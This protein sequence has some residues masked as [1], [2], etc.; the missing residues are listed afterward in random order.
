[1]C[2]ICMSENELE[3]PISDIVRREIAKQIPISMKTMKEVILQLVS[4]IQKKREDDSHRYASLTTSMTTLSSNYSSTTHDTANKT[5]DLQTQLR[6]IQQLVLQTLTATSPL[7]PMLQNA[8][9]STPPEIFQKILSDLAVVVTKSHEAISLLSALLPQLN[10]AQSANLNSIAELVT[11]KLDAL[12]TEESLLGAAYT[13]ESNQCSEKLKTMVEKNV[14]ILNVIEKCREETVQGLSALVVLLEGVAKLGLKMTLI[15]EKVSGI[16]AE[17]DNILKN[18]DDRMITYVE[19]SKS[20]QDETA[21]LVKLIEQGIQKSESF[22]ENIQESL[23]S[24]QLSYSA[25]NNI[26]E[27]KN[28]HVSTCLKNIKSEIDHMKNTMDVPKLSISDVEKVVETKLLS[29]F[30]GFKS[31]ITCVFTSGL[32]VIGDEIKNTIDEKFRTIEKNIK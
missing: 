16:S 25:A 4:E 30:D 26:I 12:R 13:V 1:L 7:I 8:V 29:I 5:A 24:F 18:I 22:Q 10:A 28:Q 17:L 14:E 21:G 27:K 2:L 15:E 23:E 31:E 9:P 20:I 3:E 11:A 32:K 6:Q 19:Q